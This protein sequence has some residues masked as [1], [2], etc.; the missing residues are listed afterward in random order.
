MPRD[1]PKMS[2]RIALSS[3]AVVARAAQHLRTG[4]LV[5]FPTETVYGLGADARNPNAVHRIFAAKGRPANHPVIVHIAEM[6]DVEAWAREFPEGARRLAAAFWPGPLTLIVPRAAQVDDTV[7]GG[8]DSVG[9]RMPS[10]PVARQLL[11]AFAALGGSGIAAPSANRFGHV[12]PTTAQHVAADLGDAVAMILDGGACDVGIESTIVAFTSAN[13]VLLRPGGVSVDELIRVLGAAPRVPDA[14]APRA[15][16]TLASHYAPRTPA[17]I[18]PAESLTREIART[19]GSAAVLARTITRPGEFAGTWIGA[20]IS[21][22]A[23]AHDLYASL[24]ALDSVGSAIIL[25][26][27]VPEDSAWLAVRDRLVRATQQGTDS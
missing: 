15:P 27:D 11:T 23:Y 22:H 3:P 18:I 13:P 7:T 6:H 25:V 5:A 9:L 14:N 4:E 1:A 10:H 8:Q 12:S 17:R 19:G 20:P 16:G 24:R 21:A 26:E 2:D